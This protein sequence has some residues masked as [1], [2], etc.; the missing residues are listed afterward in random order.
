M[1]RDSCDHDMHQ[2]DDESTPDCRETQ[3]ACLLLPK[4][5]PSSRIFVRLLSA[6]LA[7]SVLCLGCTTTESVRRCTYDYSLP[8]YPRETCRS[9]DR[10]V[11]DDM[12]T[13][14]LVALG[15]LG[16]IGI[17]VVLG[18]IG[19]AARR[20]ERERKL[21]NMT[22]SQRRRY[23]ENERATERIRAE[24]LREQALRDQARTGDDVI[25]RALEEAV[26]DFMSEMQ[27]TSDYIAEQQ[28]HTNDLL[29]EYERQK[30]EAARQAEAAAQQAEAA[31]QAEAAARQ[32][33]AARQAEA[34]AQQAEAARQAEAAARQA[35]AAR[36]A[37][38]A[39]QQAEAARQAEAAAQQA[40]AARQAE[41]A[42]QQAQAARQAEAAARQAEAARRAEAAAQQAQVQA[43]IE[44]QQDAERQSEAEGQAAIARQQ[45]AESEAEL[46]HQQEEEYLQP[47]K[48]IINSCVTG[49]G[50]A[51]LSVER[52][53]VAVDVESSIPGGSKHLDVV[54]FEVVNVGDDNAYVLWRNDRFTSPQWV[55][56]L[57]LGGSESPIFPVRT[58]A[59]KVVIG[60]ADA[61]SPFSVRIQ[62]M[63][64]DESGLDIAM[65]RI[66][67]DNLEDGSLNIWYFQPNE[68]VRVERGTYAVE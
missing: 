39:A 41:A 43:T 26:G 22:E 7:I 52:W 3:G 58:Q 68:A 59:G 38:A 36:Q 48:V 57:E 1:M 63:C 14:L 51:R 24:A 42:S 4:R 65:D 62:E 44:R 9:E 12:K 67:W 28:R 2:N 17:F 55:A 40:Q 8:P 27:D 61:A 46:Q 54:D 32:A 13:A 33:Q 50:F 23:L 34:A 29:H 20:D 64:N 21:A 18:S 6:V 25:G 47:A 5:R 37:E 49:E 53:E 15:A 10:E 11:P 16:V 31:R 30:A 60:Y 45:E 19:D 66:N 35:Q 56:V